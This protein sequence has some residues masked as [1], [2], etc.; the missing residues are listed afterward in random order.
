MLFL[1]QEEL[2][3]H[4]SNSVSRTPKEVLHVFLIRSA[5]NLFVILLLIGM[6]AAII[7][8]A[9][10]SWKQVCSCRAVNFYVCKQN[11]NQCHN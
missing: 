5:T 3:E 11:F 9:I 1:V 6:T 8:A 7:A 10:Y 4:V 2:A